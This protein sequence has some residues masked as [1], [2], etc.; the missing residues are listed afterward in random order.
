MTLKR[1]AHRASSR[2][3]SKIRNPLRVG[4][5]NQA[6]R[7]TWLQE[8]LS[9]IP[10]GRRILDAG[11]G[12]RQYQKFCRHLDYVSQDFAQYD[13]QGT[14]TGL[15]TGTWDNR[16]LDIVSDIAQIPEPDESF[17][18]ILCVEVLEHIPHPVDALRELTRL[19]KEDGVL[20]I[21]APFCSL[22]H[23][24]PY[25]FQTGYSRYF[26]ERWLGQLGFI[27]EDMRW[28]GNYFEYL[29]QELRRLPSV[30]EQYAGVR[31]GWWQRRAIRRFLAILDR[32]SKND[33]GGS[34]QLLS[35]GLHI[36]A[37]KKRS[38]G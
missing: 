34:E 37:R 12:E 17:E 38:P 28:N 15:Q 27:I 23:F 29:A 8:T 14:G 1:I 32:L 19:L 30:A 9:A 24:A 21:T 13:G 36:R 5:L 10:A 6:T 26:Y 18:I 16:G 2:I 35:F 20:I 4:T 11:A 33:H 7:E 3:F 31:L 25:F 22:T